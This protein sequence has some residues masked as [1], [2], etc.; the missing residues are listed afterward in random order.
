MH[1]LVQDH[2]DLND[3][4]FEHRIHEI[5]TK[6]LH[7]QDVSDLNPNEVAAVKLWIRY[8]QID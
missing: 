3:P 7:N 2:I 4:M 6:I 5:A 8:Q 1:Y